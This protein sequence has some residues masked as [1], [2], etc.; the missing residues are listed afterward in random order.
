MSTDWN[1]ESK[2]EH[3]TPKKKCSVQL[4]QSIVCAVIAL[5]IFGLG[6]S[7]SA[8]Y[9]SVKA[10]YQT[11]MQEDYCRDGVWSV[12]KGV[13]H[14]VLDP[15]SPEAESADA[16]AVI[17]ERAPV[18]TIASGGEDIRILDA[19]EDTS[20]EA[21]TV[22]QKAVMPVQ[23]KVTSGFG[24]RIHPITGNRSFHTGI[25]LAAPEG[26]EILA[27]YGGT[28]EETGFTNGRG[29]FILLRHGENLQT[30]YCHLSE[31]DV[32]KGDDVSAGERIGKV[33]STGLS[34]GPH[35]HFELRVDGIRCNPVY[36]LEG[37]EYV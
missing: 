2:K 36:V 34:T 8:F 5:C 3:K 7:E 22:S 1:T 10:E 27:S 33:G 28:V 19:L 14:S 15:I 35:L 29:N 11:W 25:D 32:R 23:G 18:E 24:Y 37:L 16:T 6:H 17:D 26:T 12:A 4:V 20:F 30:L 21:V 31:I 9:R 13:V